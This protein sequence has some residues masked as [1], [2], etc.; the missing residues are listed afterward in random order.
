[1]T[2]HVYR[3][4]DAQLGRWISSD[5]IGLAGGINLHQYVVASNPLTYV[6]PDGLNPLVGVWPG[7]EIG[8]TI[9]G[10]VGAIVGEVVAGAIGLVIGTELAEWLNNKL[11]AEHDKG[12]RPSTKEKHEKGDERRRKDQGGVRLA[13][14]PDAD[15]PRKRPDWYPRE[16]PW[17]PKPP[18]SPD[19]GMCEK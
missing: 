8:G 4:Y 19:G 10:P 1:M 5:P 18:K 17:P 6:D 3:A 12:K 9:G 7:V 2:S 15:P 11:A 16:G 14:Q 13:E